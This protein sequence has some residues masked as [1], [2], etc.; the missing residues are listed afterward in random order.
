LPARTGIAFV[1]VQHLDPNH[2]SILAELLGNFT[3]MTVMQVHSELPVRP[4]HVYVIPPNATMVIVD[5]ILRVSRPVQERSYRRKPIDAFF[6]SLAENMR[7]Q[8]IGVI[9]SGADSDGTLGLEAIKAEGSITFAQNDTAKFDAMPRSAIAAGAVD[10]VLAPQ[11][12]AHELAVLARH[13]IPRPVAGQLFGDSAAMDEI[14]EMDRR[15]RTFLQA[16][17]WTA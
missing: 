14:L 3:A 12:I 17:F 11:G 13:R 4:D 7:D 2:E 5:G 9:L 10:F 1:L 16:G 8:A 6:V 15:S